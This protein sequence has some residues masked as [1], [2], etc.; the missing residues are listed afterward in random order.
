MKNYRTTITLP[1]EIY[2][3][4]KVRA[5][6]QNKSVSRFIRDLL[7]GISPTGEQK[8]LELPFG[9]FSLGIRRFNRKDLYDSYLKRKISY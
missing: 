6:Y 3:K 4:T 1:T 7:Q 2:R 9:T 5:A 8:T